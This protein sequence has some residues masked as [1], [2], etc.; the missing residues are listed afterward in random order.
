MFSDFFRCNLEGFLF[1]A[2]V[3]NKGRELWFFSSPPQQQ[4]TGGKTFSHIGISLLSMKQGGFVVHVVR[5]CLCWASKPTSAKVQIHLP[6]ALVSPGTKTGVRMVW[7]HITRPGK[8]ATTR[9][10]QTPRN[11]PPTPP[12]IFWR[13]AKYGS[14]GPKVFQWIQQNSGN[15]KAFTFRIPR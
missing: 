5:C 7:W 2:K 14:F 12:K 11:L 10:Q 8:K 4:N 6:L 9:C 15:L 1:W 3:S 13:W